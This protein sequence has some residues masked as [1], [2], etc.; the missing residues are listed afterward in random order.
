MEKQFRVA[1]LYICTGKYV[2]FW[3]NF[4]QSFERY[5]LRKS[6]IEYF[7]FTDAAELF[8]EKMNGRIHRIP[9]ENLGWP[10]NTLF[11]FQM[12][13]SIREWIVGFD[14]A[15][16]FNANMVCMK[17]ITEEEFL[18][19]EQELLM[20]QHPGYYKASVK[21]LPY[22]HRKESLACVP[23]REGKD[24]VYGAVNG[25]KAEAFLRMAEEL[26]SDIK[27]DYEKGIIA[28]WHDESHLNCYIWKNSNYRLLTPAYAYPEG[29]KLPFEEKIKVLDKSQKIKLDLNKVY[30]LE[31][32]SA[33]KRAKRKLINIWKK[34]K[35]SKNQ[36]G[37]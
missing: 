13:N 18:P 20:V 29:W 32:R 2:V 5:F 27:I 30:E 11:R 25:G 15:F 19:L 14:F 21:R 17:K 9:Q 35:V 8:D 24:Y 33:L 36:I 6:E 22:E 7:V 28:K 34:R 3:K 37:S 16:F 23:R 1:L 10:N 4:Y 31:Q 26:E 12:F